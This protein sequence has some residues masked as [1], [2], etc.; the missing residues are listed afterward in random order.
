LA[1][2]HARGR[3]AAV[4]AAV[5]ELAPLQ[6]VLPRDAGPHGVIDH[7]E[8]GVSLRKI[9][10]AVNRER[11]L[12]V[13]PSGAGPFEYGKLLRR[14]RWRRLIMAFRNEGALLFIILPANAEGLEQFIEDTD[15]VVLVGDVEY[16]ETRHVVARVASRAQTTGDVA[17]RPSKPAA[18]PTADVAANRKV[19]ARRAAM[20]VAATLVLVAASALV[21][22]RGDDASMEN[23]SAITSPSA[24]T[25]VL[26]NSD[27]TGGAF[28]AVDVVMLNS[29]A[30]AGRQLSERLSGVPAA[31][32]SP[33]VLGT[34]SARWYRVLAGAWP[35]EREA[36]S[37]LAALR[38]GGL[39]PMGFGTVRRTPF[40]V[41]IVDSLPPTVA[42]AR[43]T[44]LR[45]T[46]FPAYALA[47][48]SGHATVYAGAFETPSQATLLLDMFKQAGIAASVAYRIG[49]GL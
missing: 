47:R 38:T 27:T 29:L 12:F 32:F 19:F 48:D 36:D 28:Y 6:A 3:P 33:V 22:G 13:V 45:A 34:D 46:G 9:A 31:T 20:L 4:V 30:D 5:G 43:A 17:A 10:K 40:A 7:F 15:G 37:A 14:E 35:S 44:E 8:S 1:R 21:I 26:A 25:V 23:D 42:I 2:A 11:T 39:V 24:G 16:P 41:R 49:R 18:A